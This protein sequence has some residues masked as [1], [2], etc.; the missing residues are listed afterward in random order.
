MHPDTETLNAEFAAQ[1]RDH[2]HADA[3]VRRAARNVCGDFA[4]A[5][6]IF[7]LL[8]LIAEPRLFSFLC[9]SYRRKDHAYGQEGGNDTCQNLFHSSLS[10]FVESSAPLSESA[11]SLPF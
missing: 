1:I 3:A 9:T 11:G 4:H 7:F 6:Q 2:F 5:E 10:P 8:D